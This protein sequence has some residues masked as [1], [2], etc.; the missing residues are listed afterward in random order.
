MLYQNRS[1]WRLSWFFIIIVLLI[2]VG[3]IFIISSVLLPSNANDSVI[4]RLTENIRTAQLMLEA[5]ETELM[6]FQKNLRE[7]FPSPDISVESTEQYRAL[8]A[9][10]EH[11]KEEVK[12]LNSMLAVVHSV[13]AVPGVLPSESFDA[14]NPEAQFIPT[15][16][17][18]ILGM[19]R[20]GTSVV[21]GLLNKMG[22][23]AGGP[24]IGPAEDN[25]KGFFERIDV[26]LQNDYIMRSQGV[27][28]AQNTYRYDHLAGLQEM[29]DKREPA[30]DPSQWFSEGRRALKFLNDEAS[31]PWMLKDPRLCIT[32]RSWLPL[33]NFHPAV[34]FIFRHP[35]DVALS[36]HHREGFRIGKGLR[37]WYVYNKRALQQSADLC[38]VFGSQRQVMAD[39]RAEIDRIHDE[40][41]DRCHVPVPHKVSNADLT[42][43]I[44]PE[45]QHG[46]TSKSDG[47]CE[48]LQEDPTNIATIVPPE[49]SWVPENEAMTQLYREAIRVF[50]AMQDGSA[51]GPG[52][53]W[54]EQIMDD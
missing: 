18:V 12:E 45:L 51:F 21:G 30:H 37:M 6:T 41:R 35:L 20:S 26:V 3:Y 8:M 44:D 40:L 50:C 5:K 2:I 28:Y 14:I 9:E 52:F 34:V 42:A 19:H 54:D 43:F 31:Y 23:N 16:G 4:N 33:L 49:K 47:N 38:R 24:L 10:N 27:H 17:V 7:R 39:S 46:R 53:H 29:M 36:L 13:T 1:S 32:V 15:Q 25:A 48:L 11:L 22:L